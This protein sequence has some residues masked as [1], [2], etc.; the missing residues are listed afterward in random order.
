MKNTDELENLK[1]Q[2]VDLQISQS[3][4]ES[5]IE[6]LEKTVALQHQEIEQLNKKLTLLSEYIKN[7]S[8]DS[9][10]KRSE[11]EVPPPHY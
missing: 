1:N 11:E 5:S 7:V 6:A 4:Q 2:I 3:Y 8:K 10:I 9:G